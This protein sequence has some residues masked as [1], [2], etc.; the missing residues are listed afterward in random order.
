MGKQANNAKRPLD[1]AT[2]AADPKRAA[3]DGAAETPDP[4]TALQTDTKVV[5]KL[6][7]SNDVRSHHN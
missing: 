2:P 7:K 6:R 5:H 4:K 3:K 1:T